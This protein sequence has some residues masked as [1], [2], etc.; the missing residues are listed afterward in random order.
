MVFGQ[1]FITKMVTLFVTPIYQNGI[2]IDTN[3]SANKQHIR[4][5]MLF[6]GPL[7]I[8]HNGLSTPI[9][10]TWQLSDQNR[11]RNGSIRDTFWRHF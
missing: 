5:F 3:H 7:D 4:C 8:A 10:F 2:S 9:E 6:L 11:F 1:L